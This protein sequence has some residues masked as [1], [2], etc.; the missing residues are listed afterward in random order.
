MMIATHFE[1]VGKFVHYSA[2]MAKRGRAE[3]RE[4]EDSSR[5]ALIRKQ[6]A[7]IEKLKEKISAIGIADSGT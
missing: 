5:D 4:D 2:R 6:K 1:V 3:C 7:E